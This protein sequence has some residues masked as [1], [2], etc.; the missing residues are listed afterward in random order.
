MVTTPA[1]GM[2]HSH[3]TKKHCPDSKMCTWIICRSCGAY[4]DPEKNRWAKGG[5]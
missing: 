4:G 3:N 1:C 2:C 5:K